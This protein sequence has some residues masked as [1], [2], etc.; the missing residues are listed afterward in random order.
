MSLQ[1][2]SGTLEHPWPVDLREL[3]VNAGR[4]MTW[5]REA[6]GP[7]RGPAV[8]AILRRVHLNPGEPWCAAFVGYIGWS[9]LRKEWPLK[10]VGGCASLAEDATHKGLLR[11]QPAPGAI[12]LLWGKQ[13][14]RFNHTGFLGE[15]LQDSPAPVWETIEGNT[16]ETGSPEGN[17]VFV[18]QRIFRTTE[19]T[20]GIDRPQAG[21]DGFIWWW[22]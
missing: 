1:T 18:R 21:Y 4:A 10:L 12:F 13:A 15:Q 19:G 20:P 3:V 5:V 14:N 6:G 22:L 2:F 9:L 8:E 17:G 11:R 7:N 16:S